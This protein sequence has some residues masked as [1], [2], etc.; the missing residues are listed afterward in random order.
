[1]ENG[2]IIAVVKVPY[3]KPKTMEIDKGLDTLQNLV[4]GDIC[5]ADLPDMDDVFGF[6]NDEG[7]LIGLKPNFYRPEYGDGIVG[8]AVFVGAGEDGTS[9]CLTP[10]QAKKVTTYL[11]ENSVGSYNEFLYHIETGF[12]NYKPKRQ[13]VM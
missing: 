13:S 3:E 6:C 2:K 12:Q 9:I 8:T 4:G 7:L 11:E 10:E 5:A 1:M